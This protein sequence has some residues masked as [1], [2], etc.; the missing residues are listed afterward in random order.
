MAKLDETVTKKIINFLLRTSILFKDT[1][2]PSEN[3]SGD[4]FLKIS[5]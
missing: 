4:T 2:S 5:I 1:F 3:D